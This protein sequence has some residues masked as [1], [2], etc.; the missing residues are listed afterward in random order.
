MKE[1][2]KK[3]ISDGRGVILTI[4]ILQLILV[5][6]VTP[7]R[8]DDE[9]FLGWISQRPIFDVLV[10]RYTNWTSRVIIDGT[11]FTLLKIS[12][13]AWMLV[14]A[15]MMA[16]IGYSISKLFLKKENR[17]QM[18]SMVLI[19][20]LIYPINLM[21]ETGWGA[22]T[23]NY[24][25]PLAT[26]LFALIPIK[27]AWDKEKFRW[28][29]FPL[30]AIALIYACNQEQTCAILFGTY[31]LFTI[32]LIIKDKKIHPMVVIQ[33]LLTVLSLVFIFT[34]PGN[35][36]RQNTEMEMNFPNFEMLTFQDKLSLG[37]T[38]TAN[39]I[40]NNYSIPFGALS[41]CILVYICIT[42]K[43]RIY[44]IIAAIPFVSICVLSY[45]RDIVFNVFP[46]FRE[47]IKVFTTSDG[48][49][50]TVANS[51]N[52]FNVFPIIF[53][54]II[55]ICLLLS[56]LIIFKNIKNNLA[57]LVF[58]VGLASRVMMGFSPTIFASGVRTT[59]FFDF[60]MLIVILLI[61]QEFSKKTE[62]N[63]IKTQ[64]KLGIVL[65]CTGILQYINALLYILISQK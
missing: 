6:F 3:F 39:V 64:K 37:F 45:F 25:W 4:F 29:Q 31:T 28:F 1:N 65:E 7:N 30:Y 36:I 10:D 55:F 14:H 19:L 63:D 43:E 22:T 61:W 56:I 52:L 12:K 57:A 26:A 5:I 18:S 35:Y 11:I 46:Y 42:Y 41:L 40:F 62:K 21:A 50:L 23:S 20:I 49:I 27:K 51:N 8:F 34:T 16:L 47:F 59:I 2:F 17:T 48:T 32:L 15:G 9:R 54:L 24:M 60:S 58:L 53:S 33:L 13:Y 44:K 38:S